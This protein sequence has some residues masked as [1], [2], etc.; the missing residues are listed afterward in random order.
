VLVTGCARDEPRAAGIAERWLSAVN[1]QGR[2]NLRDKSIKR[3]EKYGD[4]ALAEKV[5]PPNAEDDER[6]FPDYEVGKATE[7]E[8][9]ARVPFRLTARIEDGNEEE[10]IGTIVLTRTADSW[11]VAGVEDRAPGEEVPSEGGARP[12]SASASQWVGAIIIGL[13]VMV[14]SALVIDAQPRSTAQ[15]PPG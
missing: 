6:H 11:R 9:T 5:V 13:A 12:A 4:Q 3:A 14:L 7:N 10:R 8:T 2:D 1:D 15:G